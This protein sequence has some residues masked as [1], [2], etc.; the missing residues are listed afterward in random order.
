MNLRVTSIDEYQFSICFLN[1]VFGANRNIFKKWK[2]GDFIMFLINKKIS[3][4]AELVGEPFVS[5]NILWDNGL[6][7]NRIKLS[8][9]HILKPEDRIPVEGYV[10]DLFVKSWGLHYGTGIVNKMTVTDEVAPA[11]ILEIK[12]QSNSLQYYKDNINEILNE[13]RQAREIELKEVANKEIKFKKKIIN[14]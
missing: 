3:A 4:V 7:D 1:E 13:V 2:E 12:R 6:F 5:D 8:F 9:S 10:R 14:I 11:F